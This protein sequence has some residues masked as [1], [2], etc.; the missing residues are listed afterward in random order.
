MP[1]N[2]IA[3]PRD[4]KA[5][6]YGDTLLATDAITYNYKGVA[7]K[8]YSPV[9]ITGMRDGSNNLTI[10]WIRRTRIGGYW[11]D[12]VDIPLNETTEAYEI[13]VMNGT[14]VVRTISSSIT[15]AMYSAADQT[16]DFGSVQS[17]LDI[18]IYQLSASIGRGYAGSAAV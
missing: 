13:D 10:H 3:L 9:H 6:S 14:S 16:A 12:F 7:F 4:Y 5:V 17:S 2:L 8:P 18:K 15:N 1:A 11:Q